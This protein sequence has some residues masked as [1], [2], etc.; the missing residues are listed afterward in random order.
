MEQLPLEKIPYDPYTADL[1]DA[2][3]AAGN[4]E[5]GL[6]M[7]LAFKDY[8]FERLEY[9]LKQKPYILNSAEYEIQT[10]IQYT[11]RVANSCEKYGKPEI[12]KEINDKL[13]ACYTEYM[14]KIQPSARLQ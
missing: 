13:E 5:K 6:S 10:A 4:T 12:A 3:F 2:Y 9:F 14:S 1:I 8:Y 7:S 11:S